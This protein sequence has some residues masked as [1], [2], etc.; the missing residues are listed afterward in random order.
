MRGVQCPSNA[1]L[2][3]LPHGHLLLNDVPARGVAGAQAGVQGG[4]GRVRGGVRGGVEKAFMSTTTEQAV[5]MGYAS[6]GRGAKQ[7]SIGIVIEVQQGMVNRGADI[8]RLSQ[9]PHE[10]EILCARATSCPMP[11]RPQLH[12]FSPHPPAAH[13]RSP[14][15]S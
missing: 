12:P 14:C 3:R 9:Y 10:R 4:G 13:A 7:A 6:G 1:Q 5:A 15:A 11:T 8:S 2:F